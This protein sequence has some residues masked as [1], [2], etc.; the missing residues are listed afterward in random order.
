MHVRQ[1]RC[2][3]LRVYQLVYSYN[4]AMATIRRVPSLD[5]NFQLVVTR[6]Y[7]E[8]NQEL[9]EDEDESASSPRP[10]PSTP[11]LLTLIGQ[12]TRSAYFLSGRN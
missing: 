9:L 7:E 5:H 11:L 3:C 6:V 10:Y 1:S 12:P 2:S 8:G 4:D